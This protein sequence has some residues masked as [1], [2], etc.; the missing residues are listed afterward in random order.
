MNGADGVTAIVQ[1]R[2][3]S[4]RLPNKVL[5]EIKGKPMLMYLLDGLRQ[6]R[7]LSGFIVATSRDPSDDAV[8]FFCRESGVRCHRGPLEDVAGRFMETL[9]IHGLGAFVRLSGDS[10]L[11]DYRLVDR[12]VT[13]YR[14]GCY[15]LVTNVLKRSF[16]KG[17]S[18]EVVR[19]STFSRTYPLMKAGDD[20]EHVTKYFYAHSADFQIGSFK[21]EMD[22]SG[23]QLSVD[24]PADLERIR[25]IVSIMERPHWEYTFDRLVSM[26]A[27]VAQ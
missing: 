19:A 9:G 1:A 8:E 25:R 5:T 21:S 3:N 11:M 7:L 4:R 18:V 6:S 17:Q 22:Y 14:E 27:E 16:P 20:R 12:A 2:M 15:D 26:A 13:I 23:I 10:P 24:S